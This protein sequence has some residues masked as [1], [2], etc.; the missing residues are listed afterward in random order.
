[1]VAP[2]RWLALME[3]RS[4]SSHPA[5]RRA[6]TRPGFLVLALA[7][8][9]AV[10][11]VTAEISTIA[12]VELAGESCE[13]IND[14]SPALADRCA[15]SGWERHGGALLLLAAV[16]AVAAVLFAVRAVAPAAAVLAAVGALTL[17]IA[18]IGDLPETNET[19][20]VG[21]NFEGASAQAG[22]GFY[23]ELTGG[24]LC[25]LAG[26]LAL[27]LSRRASAASSGSEPA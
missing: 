15:L 19:G 7:L 5:A 13:V 23:L 9:A 11:L 10:L 14:S 4:A 1:M 12:S 27:A 17:A 18:L 8:G 16:A 24:V 20:A 22:V 3:A 6:G 21:L 2:V 25:L 26:L